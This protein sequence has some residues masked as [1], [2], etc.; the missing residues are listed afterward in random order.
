MGWDYC[1]ATRYKNGKVDR[2]AEVDARLNWETSRFTHSVL[3]SSMVGSTYYAA[4]KESDKETGNSFVFAAIVHTSIDNR[5]PYFNFGTKLMSEDMGPFCYDCPAS[6]LNLLSETTNK[7]ALDWREKCR[8][9]QRKP[10]LSDLKIG[11]RI[12]Y[13]TWEGEIVELV[14][15]SPNYQFKR[16]WW[17]RP[18]KNTYVPSRRIPDQYE[19]IA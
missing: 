4:V 14:K 9:K 6:I 18:E 13:K 17:Y 11:T 5:D 1:C 10:K 16:A 15:M 19:I 12:S 8:E 2:K 7:N 3:K